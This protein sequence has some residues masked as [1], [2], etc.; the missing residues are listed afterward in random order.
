MVKYATTLELAAISLER[1]STVPLYLQLYQQ[2]RRDILSGQITA[3]KRLPSTRDLAIHL[4]VSRNT[5]SAAF[6]LLLAEGYIEG[7]V[8]SGTYVAQILAE[9][10][11][12]TFD[13]KNN[14]DRPKDSRLSSKNLSKQ[15]QQMLAIK[16]VA[17]RY[18]QE[19]PRAF[20]LSVPAL[21]A[22]PID[23]WSKLTT[24]HWR[25]QQADLFC[26]GDP[27]GYRPLRE[28]IAQHLKMTR[29][30]QCEAEQVIIVSGSQQ[31][32]YLAT[33]LL[34]DPGDA[35]WMEDPGYLGARS[36]FLGAGANLV[37]VPVDE[38]GL[39]VEVGIGK[40]LHAKLVY[41]TPSH[42]F[43]LG[44]SMSLTRRLSLL[45]WA[46]QSG[47]WILEDDYDS[48]YRYKGQPLTALQGL[49][50]RGNVIYMGT[51]SKVLFPALRLGY[52]VVPSELVE[53][54]A[55]ARA[56]I[57]RH[58][59]MLEQAVLADFIAEGHLTRHIRKMRMLY[60]E[61]Q[62]A[63][64]SSARSLGELI[65]VRPCDT[66]MH[67]VGWLQEG[68]CDRVVC[69]LLARQEITTRPLSSY[70]LKPPARGGLVLGYTAI[71]CDRIRKAV[72]E[73]EIILKKI[74]V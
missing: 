42:Q 36:V 32:L 45:Q 54:F 43:P 21:D 67:L 60:A 24:K 34:I 47:A 13:R 11:D 35:V 62:E 56:T 17:L 23:V 28:Q 30:I 14:R 29:A 63:L 18:R 57:D 15:A 10:M 9:R 39:N 20:C 49:D 26:Y 52:L 3:G 33:S 53:I 44:A 40:N 55:A 31:A 50:R 5:V 61:R 37:P 19:P 69:R 8:G 41:V 70:Y 16:D 25:S 66:G 12:C 58:S 2:L 59:P 64:V 22:F 6:D 71:D 4:E 1:S 74:A 38:Q 48:E 73:L 7:K 51:F 46:S 27:C 72:E 65:S 68:I